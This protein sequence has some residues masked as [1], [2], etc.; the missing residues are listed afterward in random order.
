MTQ[1]KILPEDFGFEGKKV[2]FVR[3]DGS[4]ATRAVAI[5]GEDKDGNLMFFEIASD[6]IARP[7]L[8]GKAK[9]C[10]ML[11][12]RVFPCLECDNIL[13]KSIDK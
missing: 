12:Q 10:R 7:K 13:D 9:Y 4:K 1:L 3:A 2:F 5:G 6:Q 11:I 8:N